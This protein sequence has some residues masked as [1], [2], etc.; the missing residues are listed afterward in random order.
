MFWS[1]GLGNQKRSHEWS[2]CWQILVRKRGKLGEGNGTLW[3]EGQ[4]MAHGPLRLERDNAS[5]E[6]LMVKIKK[7]NRSN[8]VNF[9]VLSGT[10]PAQWLIIGPF[11]NYLDPVPGIHNTTGESSV[12]QSKAEGEFGS[13]SVQA[14]LLSWDKTEA[15]RWQREGLKF[16]RGSVNLDLWV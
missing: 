12:A 15:R 16:P 13:H 11:R 14:L 6:L 10:G 1:L 7:E 5:P 9:W 4:G 3:V 2:D 8:Q